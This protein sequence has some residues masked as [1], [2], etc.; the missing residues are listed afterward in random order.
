M[1]ETPPVVKVLVAV[2]I[3]PSCDLLLHRAARLTERLAGQLLAVHVH[4]PGS[5]TDV[6][7]ANVEWN[8]EYARS[9]G[10]TISTV[11]G[12]DIAESL[13]NFGRKHD[14]NILVVGQSDI[15]RWQE[16]VRGSVINRI[17][18]MH[19]GMD[20]YVVSDESPW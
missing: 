11:E 18:R 9:L 17:L 13:V 8:L 5:G 14:A 19:P 7:Q 4:P 6:S 16:A 3:N 1:E 15:S 20:L 10:A 12:R 2:G